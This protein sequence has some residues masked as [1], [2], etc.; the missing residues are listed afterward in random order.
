MPIPIPTLLLKIVNPAEVYFRNDSAKWHKP[1]P[2]FEEAAIFGPGVPGGSRQATEQER[3]QLRS[4]GE[5]SAREHETSLA[6]ASDEVLREHGDEL[7]DG[8]IQILAGD[9]FT[10]ACNAGQLQARLIRFWHGDPLLEMEHTS[11][12]GGGRSLSRLSRKQAQSPDTL[13]SYLVREVA[14]MHV[15]RQ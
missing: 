5:R 8:A 7:R 9:H 1:G 14:E 15:H 6:A 4:Q 2:A 10:F 13:S 11:Q 12:V 3:D